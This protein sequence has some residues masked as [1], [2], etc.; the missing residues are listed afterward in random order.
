MTNMSNHKR[1]IHFD[2]VAD[3]EVLYHQPFFNKPWNK[4]KLFK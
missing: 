1:D 4:L 2:T 3:E